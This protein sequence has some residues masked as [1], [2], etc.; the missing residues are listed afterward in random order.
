V[1]GTARHINPEDYGAVSAY[2]LLQ[3]AAH[4][5]IGLD[6]RF[7]NAILNRR[8]AALPDLVR[9]GAEDHEKDPVPLEEDLLAIF[10]HWSAPEALPYYLQLI[11]REPDEVSDELI[12]C[13]VH[14]GAPALEPLLALYEKLGEEN[15]GDIGFL[16]SALRVRDARILRLLTERLEYDLS[17][18]VLCLDIYGDPAAIPALEHMLAQ[19]PEQDAT[20]RNELVSTIESLQKPKASAEAEPH[21]PF[22]LFDIYPEE[23]SPVFDVLT[24]AELLGMLDSTSPKRRAEVAEGFF[25]AELTAKAKARLFEVA[26]QDA[27]AGV[28][29]LAWEALG[30]HGEEPEIRKALLAVMSDRARPLAERSGALVALASQTDNAKV[31]AAIEDLYREPGGRAKALEAM[32]RSFNPEFVKYPPMHLD[33][34]D[35]AIRRHAI[36]GIGQLGISREAARLK[37]F[38][39]VEELRPDAIFNYALS[40]PSEVTRA[41]IRGLLDKI[42]EAAN[43]LTTAE[44]DLVQMALDQRLALKGLK[45]VFVEEE[46]PAA[47]AAAAVKA[48]R[49]DPCPCGSGKKFKKCCGA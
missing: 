38:F 32:W 36:W 41:R 31:F 18:A 19:L 30:E 46:E 20:L 9:F 43:G 40:L 6:H 39:D 47:P 7:L 28:R 15:A 44:T 2:E 17:D 25:Q 33:D 29:G 23:A 42:E 16:L 45:P 4:G 5:Y 12:D 27:D 49:N 8:E 37:P 22:D 1:S 48:G 24:E 14:L 26:R 34:P 13:L 11:S 21:G 10:R 35:L 3:S